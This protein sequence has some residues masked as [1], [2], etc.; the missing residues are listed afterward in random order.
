MILLHRR[1]LRRQQ[2]IDDMLKVEI[3]SLEFVQSLKQ[4]YEIIV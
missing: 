1:Y 4:K 3:K 2:G